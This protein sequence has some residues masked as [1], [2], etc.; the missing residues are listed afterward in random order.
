MLRGELLPLLPLDKSEHDS[1][2]GDVISRLDSLGLPNKDWD[3]SLRQ[4]L[5]RMCAAEPELRLNAQQ[6]I[7]LLRAFSEQSAGP[8]L[9]A[10]ATTTVARVAEDVYGKGTDGA[11]SGSRLFIAINTAEKTADPQQ[12]ATQPSP[13]IATSGRA[14][15]PDPSAS[16]VQVSRPATPA[17]KLEARPDAPVA[18]GPV[19][20]A[21]TSPS[22]M[23]AKAEDPLPSNSRALR[24]SPSPSAPAGRRGEPSRRT[25]PPPFDAEAAPAPSKRG[26]I[27]GAAVVFI[28]FFGVIALASVGG[29]AWYLWSRGPAAP[30]VVAA[31]APAPR[32]S[33]ESTSSA[34]E[35]TPAGGDAALE[36]TVKVE[37]RSPDD[38]VQW[39][40]LE[41]AAGK[42]VLSG[43]PNG[44]AALPT[45]VYA[46]SAKVAARAKVEGS[47][48]L[49]QD[50][51]LVCVP[52][53][54]QKVRCADEAGQTV[55]ILTA[56]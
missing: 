52:E 53:R 49:K 10:F 46:L 25:Q 39:I 18:R 28:A 50:T 20:D 16:D 15:L 31:G 34:A 54:D 13:P 35:R 37:L 14:A 30:D 22:A 40:R 32:A 48:E 12:V 7:Q 3:Q 27:I 29:G 4:T 2:L 26:L 23:P 55:V 8:S 11:L 47:L 9:D 41:D 19:A 6:I 38:T 21:R 51:H 42:R 45:G 36:G 5:A 1:A 43:S 33:A 56:S 17:R 24:G 44:D